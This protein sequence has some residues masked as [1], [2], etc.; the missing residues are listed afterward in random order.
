[1]PVATKA[2]AK[3]VNPS[4]LYELGANAII[5]NALILSIRPGEK[6]LKKMGGIGKFMNYP[7]INVTDLSNL[8]NINIRIER[9]RLVFDYEEL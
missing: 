4:K 6:F 1:M 7:G 3:F 9:F 5:S 8:R 2:T